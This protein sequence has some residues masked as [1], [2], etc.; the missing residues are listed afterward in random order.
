[1]VKSKKGNLIRNIENY[2]S[3]VILIF[4]VVLL[5]VEVIGRT[6]FSTGIPGSLDYIQHLVLWI[7]FLGA[8]ITT[9]EGKHLSLS[10]SVEN[11]K[12]PVKKW[13]K[14]AI[15]FI[16]VNVCTTLT[17]TSVRFVIVGFDTSQKVGFLPVHFFLLVM[18]IGFFIITLRFIKHAEGGLTE[19]LVIS[20]GAL[21]AILFSLHS[22]FFLVQDISLF[23]N[24]DDFTTFD[25]MEGILDTYNSFYSPVLSILLWPLVIILVSSAILG[26]PIFIVMGGLAIVFFANS[27]LSI[28]DI[29]QEAYTVLSRNEIPAIPLFTLTGFLLSESK[30]GERFVGFFKSFIGWL[31]GGLAIVSILV[32]AFFTTFTGASGVTILALGGL[33]SIV[34]IKRNYKETFSYGLLT[35]SGSVGLL[36]PPS[37][38]LIMYG[39]AA[40][41][42]I[43]DLFIG[44]IFPGIL[45]VLTL[46]IMG[47]YHAVKNNVK[48]I[49]FKL[50]N[51]LGPLKKSLPELLLPII[52]LVCFFSGFTTLVETGAIA[53]V[54]VLIIEVF[55]YKDIKIKDLPAV[56]I[57]GIPIVGGILIILAIAKGFSYYIIDQRIPLHLTAWCEKNITSPVLFLIL[58][59]IGLLITGCFMDIFSAILVVA[60][61][62]IPLGQL[63]R[64]H[65]VH[66]GII[67]LANLQLGYMT[68]PVGL[69]LFL[70]SYR[71]NQP[72]VKIYK[73]VLPFFLAMLVSVLLV[74]YVPPLTTI[75]LKP[76]KNPGDVWLVKKKNNNKD[77]A[78]FTT[79][80]HVDTGTQK[81]AAYEFEIN[82]DP[83]L[84]KLYE[85]TGMRGVVPG[86]NG[87]VTSVNTDNP[88]IL[89]IQGLDIFGKLPGRDLYMADINWQAISEGNTEYLIKV[90]ILKDESQEDIGKPFG[91]PLKVEL[92]KTSA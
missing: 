64:I 14:M 47:I 39:V 31:P 44:G 6:F 27:G 45:L 37:L 65:P 54:Y 77:A 84:V 12:D 70:A 8:M 90:N 72:L 2:F 76:V 11:I 52:I 21:V 74:T 28:G 17:L 81:F 32:C 87:F 66:L 4:I 43:R 80:V 48:R 68:P 41:V 71:F 33:L 67:F 73:Q 55:V 23:I 57:K 51:I 86:P 19:K 63:Y 58:L 1:M 29:P 18:P 25:K 40:A 61:L 30:A 3:F 83:A 59:N 92:K 79:E 91:I 24:P 78:F 22:I 46:C 13:I 89:V 20:S 69:N 50:K 82:Y 7:A 53:V 36:F 60:P 75:F 49:P 16:S 26:A 5:L 15:G 56:F 9:R 88:G 34:L 35:G 10:I 62:V 42:S 85:K 38:P